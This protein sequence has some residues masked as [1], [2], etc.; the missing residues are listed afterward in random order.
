MSLLSICESLTF[1][2][3]I[4]RSS[5]MISN[6]PDAAASTLIVTISPNTIFTASRR[7]RSGAYATGG[8]A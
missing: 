3:A 4:I 5:S 8:G 6:T 7:P 2:P 1:S